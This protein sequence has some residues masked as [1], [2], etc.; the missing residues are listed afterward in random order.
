LRACVPLPR[1][2]TDAAIASEGELGVLHWEKR[3]AVKTQVRQLKQRT[4]IPADS[5]SHD[6][7]SSLVRVPERQ[8]QA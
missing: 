3:E 7:I 6:V 8:P 2:Y 5:M 4:Q 1:D